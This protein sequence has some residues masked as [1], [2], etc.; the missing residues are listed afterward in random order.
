MGQRSHNKLE[1]V[2]GVGSREQM[3]VAP[4]GVWAGRLHASSRSGRA[5]AGVPR[6]QTRP[7]DGGESRNH[8]KFERT[9]VTE[10]PRQV[11]Y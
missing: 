11:H 1:G 9:I 4:V 2:M 6:R 5:K 8:S 3:A 7:A 10:R